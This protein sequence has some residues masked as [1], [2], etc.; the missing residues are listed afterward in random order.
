MLP[1]IYYSVICTLENNLSV[2]RAN[3][4][5]FSVYKMDKHSAKLQNLEGFTAVS[6][7]DI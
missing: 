4:I 6:F 5:S 2:G 1:N 3:D 7:S